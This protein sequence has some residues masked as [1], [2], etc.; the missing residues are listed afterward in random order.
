MPPAYPELP[1]A[2][3]GGQKM[4]NTQALT[5]S[6]LPSYFCENGKMAAKTR[7]ALI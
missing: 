2:C 7:K 6:P 5:A 3:L 4:F 1:I